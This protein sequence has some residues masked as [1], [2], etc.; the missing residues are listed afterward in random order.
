MCLP[1]ALVFHRPFQERSI[2]AVV[3][4]VATALIVVKLDAPGIASELAQR[5]IQ[6]ADLADHADVAS[7]VR[8]SMGGWRPVELY[9]MGVIGFAL[10][11]LLPAASI[12][13]TLFWR[14]IHPIS[15]LRKGMHMNTWSFLGSGHRRTLFL[16][17]R[18]K[19]LSYMV[20]ITAYAGKAYGFAFK[21]TSSN[22]KFPS[23]RQ[24]VSVS[25]GR[26]SSSG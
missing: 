2:T 20:W 25:V 8:V 21:T 4:L 1:L 22:G 15:P 13:T 26:E 12:I 14:C 17:G 6:L 5:R 23:F 9:D 10:T 19:Q 3:V 16:A 7:C 11:S 18:L 24:I